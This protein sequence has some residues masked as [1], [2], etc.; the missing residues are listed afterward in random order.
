M[1]ARSPPLD[2]GSDQGQNYGRGGD[3]CAGWIMCWYSAGGG[4]GGTPVA[5]SLPL[6]VVSATWGL[7]VYDTADFLLMLLQLMLLMS[8]LL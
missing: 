7:L 6:L 3:S 4:S 8:L 5:L 2:V 1:I